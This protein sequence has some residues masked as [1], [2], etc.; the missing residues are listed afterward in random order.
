MKPKKKYWLIDVYKRAAAKLNIGWNAPEGGGNA[1]RDWFDEKRIPSRT[2]P[3]KQ[4]LPTVP[5]CLAEA[6]RNKE[7]LLYSNALTMEFAAL[8]MQGMEVL[9]FS[10]PPVGE[11]SLANHHNPSCVSSL[12]SISLPGKMESFSVSILQKV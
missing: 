4:L 9:G 10:M 12:T 8:D 11:Q 5:A 7:K 2:I 3:G 6:K 1:E